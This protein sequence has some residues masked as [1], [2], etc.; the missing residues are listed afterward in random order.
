MSNASILTTRTLGEAENA[1]R[2]LLHKILAET[3]LDYH[4]WVA[5]K[6]VAESSSPISTP[7]LASRLEGALKV[8]DATA[9]RIIAALRAKGI[10]AAEREAV[11]LTPDGATLLKRLN[12][13]IQRVTRQVW[14]GLSV[15]DLTVAQRVLSTIT[16]RANVLLGTDPYLSFA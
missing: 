3:A 16:E 9:A 8:D 7:A 4:R 5:L 6:L 2:A 11:S 14:E 15:E 10:F 1:L 12:E 13:E